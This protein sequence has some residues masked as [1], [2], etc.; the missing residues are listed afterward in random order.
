VT[1]KSYPADIRLYCFYKFARDYAESLSSCF[2]PKGSRCEL[3]EAANVQEEDFGG[4]GS[5][6]LRLCHVA[7]YKAHYMPIKNFVA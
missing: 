4:R 5:N 6:C 1:L 7:N 3:R 2:I